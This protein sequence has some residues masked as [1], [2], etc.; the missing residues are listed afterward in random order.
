MDRGY[1]SQ[2]LLAIKVRAKEYYWVAMKL[3]GIIVDLSFFY[4]SDE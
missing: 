3:K 4:V 2:K 1:A